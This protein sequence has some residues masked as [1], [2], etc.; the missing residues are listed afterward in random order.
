MGAV[1]LGFSGGEPLVS[2]QFCR[3]NPYYGWA[4]HNR[5]QLMPSQEQLH[6]AE[7]VA[8]EYQA[9]QQGRMKIYYLVPDYDEGHPKACMNGWRTTFLTIAPDGLALPCHSARQ[10]P[11]FACPSVRDHSISDIWNTSTVFSYFSGNDWMK[12]PAKVAPKKI[13]TSAAVIAKLFY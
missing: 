7:V 3:A 10:L 13:K 6:S 5:D 4:Q 2:C 1:Q 8:K 9:S 12:N 11:N